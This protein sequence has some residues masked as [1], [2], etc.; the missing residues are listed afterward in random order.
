MHCRPSGSTES[1]IA[2]EICLNRI[3]F[4]ARWTR[5]TQIDTQVILSVGIVA[6]CRKAV[7][8]YRTVNPGIGMNTSSA[9][10]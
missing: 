5:G 8:G 7:R 3:L 6:Y 4:G 1:K 9:R 10:D 2:L